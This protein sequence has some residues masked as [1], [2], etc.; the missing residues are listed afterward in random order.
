MKLTRS[1]SFSCAVEAFQ[2]L[3]HRTSTDDVER[4]GIRGLLQGFDDQI[5]AFMSHKASIHEEAQVPSGV[6][7]A[8]Q[9]IETVEHSALSREST[10]CS[11]RHPH[12]L[13][14]W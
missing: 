5:G 9:G 3:Q 12:I 11:S 2:T 7:N 8:W 6:R 1:C 13:S 4:D 14:D 10:N